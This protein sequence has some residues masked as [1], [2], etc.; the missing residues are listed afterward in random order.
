MVVGLDEVNVNSMVALLVV[1]LLATFA[2]MVMLGG[3]VGRKY[4]V[5]VFPKNE[6]FAEGELI[7]VV[8]IIVL[9]IVTVRL[10]G[11][12]AK[13]LEP[14]DVTEVGIVTD[15]NIEQLLKALEPIDVTQLGIVIDVK[16]EQLAN[17]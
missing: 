3:G 2:V 13:A 6:L 14:I 4:L 8:P 7:R 1:A 16:P 11:V 15:V 9:L 10:A 12:L 17:M 5:V